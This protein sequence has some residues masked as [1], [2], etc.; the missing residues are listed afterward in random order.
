MVMAGG[1][2]HGIAV[3]FMPQYSPFLMP[4]ESLF[5][6]LAMAL[7]T[8]WNGIP[9]R[10]FDKPLEGVRRRGAGGPSLEGLLKKHLPNI[11]TAERVKAWERGCKKF[12]RACRAM[13]PLTSGDRA[14]SAADIATWQEQQAAAAAS[15]AGA[16]VG[17]G[18]GSGSGAGA[19]N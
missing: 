5:G 7:S 6:D 17:A 12:F 4:I 8:D 9:T 18:A 13:M 10:L 1:D 14:P 11:A 3:R 16:G 15:G 2:E 19:A